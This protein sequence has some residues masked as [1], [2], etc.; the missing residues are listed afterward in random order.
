MK[1]FEKRFT[2][3]KCLELLH[4]LQLP[5]HAK[6]A[7]AVLLGRLQDHYEGLFPA[8]AASHDL[9]CMDET[10][11]PATT[12]NDPATTANLITTTTPDPHHFPVDGKK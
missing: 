10:A 8:F 11:L 6:E 1:A 4:D 9:R 2:A 3:K 12:D 5:G 7:K